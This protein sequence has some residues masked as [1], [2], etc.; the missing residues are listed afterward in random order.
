MHRADLLEMLAQALSYGTVRTGQ[1]CV[2]FAQD[3]DRARVA[4]A[5]G[6]F[7]EADA[8]IGAD[9][10]HSHMAGHVVEP[11]APMYSGYV[12]YRGLVPSEAVAEWPT[13]VQL[14]WMGDRQH[15]MVYPVRGGR[16][17]NYVGF[18]PNAASVEESWSGEGDPDEL[19][20]AFASW[21]P[22]IGS[23]LS[24]VDTTYWWGLYDRRPLPAW[25]SGRLALLGDA[26]HPM[27]PH[28]GQ[29]ANQTMEDGVALA[30][31]LRRIAPN[32]VPE[33]LMAYESLRKPRTTVVQ[34]G[35]RANGRRYDSDYADLAQ[36]DAEIAGA[37]AL[38]AW[39]YDHDVV[40]EAG[41]LL[42]DLNGR[43]ERR[44][45]QLS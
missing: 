28:L 42:A 32:S 20:A 14:V 16:M 11:T 45:A 39:L 15:F 7:V 43:D 27:L 17:L 5:D 36:R 3:A 33:V 31:M 9:G 24:H 44:I 10:I 12:A 4:F 8:V 23:L 35:A 38:R 40:K 21:D 22:M 2:D 30:A 26:A 41:E 18:L 37:G 1:R 13:D 6:T 34:D 29:G 25:T 19:R